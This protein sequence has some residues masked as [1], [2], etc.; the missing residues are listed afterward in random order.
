MP[1]CSEEGYVDRLS[2]VKLSQSVVRFTEDFMMYFGSSYDVWCEAED[3]RRDTMSASS[4]LVETDSE[5]V[6]ACSL[7]PDPQRRGV[8]RGTLSLAGVSRPAGRYW[9]CAKIG[10]DVVFRIDVEA[11]STAS[12]T[13]P[14]PAPTPSGGSR[15]TVVDIGTLSGSVV[16]VSDMTQV[17]LA[18]DYT[19]EP[20]D[21]R[22]S[23]DPFEAYVAVTAP[24]GRFPFTD[25]LV[26]GSSPVWDRKDSILLSS[27][28]WTVHVV[29][30]A[31]TFRAELRSGKA[32]GAEID[33]DGNLVNSMEVNS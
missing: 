1:E 5:I 15:W 9:L 22:V 28:L 23:D 7:F 21:I 25:V 29:K 16:E 33:P 31:G 20:L 3:F 6:A 12:G 13:A 11:F 10:G 2:I 30:V 24:G 14:T 8:R 17:K 4:L 19:S 18:A 27:S 26:N 32:A